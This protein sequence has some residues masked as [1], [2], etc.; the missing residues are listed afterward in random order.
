MRQYI[1]EL[2]QLVP[3][4]N[5][6]YDEQTDSLTKSSDAIQEYLDN[7]QKEIELQAEEEHA[8]ELMKKTL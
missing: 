2:N 3:G 1:A 8:L 6:A 4:L 7:K 5:L